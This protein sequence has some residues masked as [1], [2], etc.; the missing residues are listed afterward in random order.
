MDGH[1]SYRGQ[2]H[3][4]MSLKDWL[5]FRFD[6]Q[7]MIFNASA[8]DGSD[9]HQAHPIGLAVFLITALP[10]SP[11]DFNP[12]A[13]HDGEYLANAIFRTS[14]TEKQGRIRVQYARQ[15]QPKSFIYSA[16]QWETFAAPPEEVLE[17]YQRTPF[18]I[19]PRGN[20]ID[21]H[22]HYEAM[23]CKSVPIIAGAD[24]SLKAKFEKL[25]VR[26]VS[27]Y[28]ILT[29]G[30]L[31]DWW[32]EMLPQVYDFNYLSRAYWIHRR[33]DVNLNY[34]SYFWLNRYKVFDNVRNYF[35]AR[36][37]AALPGQNS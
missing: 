36:E 28:T 7:D 18:T 26:Y 1:A 3:L 35:N 6:P 21:C 12:T 14:T 37:L 20:G 9:F 17:F 11:D 33:P 29:P 4:R 10:Q 15:V 13:K 30:L 16:T 27:D 8:V 24:E 22:R 31:R 5:Q 23:I 25:P 19:S 34:Q 2:R 32:D